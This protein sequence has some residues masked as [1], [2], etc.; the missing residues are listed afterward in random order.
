[1]NHVL[2]PHL[3]NSLVN[4]QHIDD[5]NHVDIFDNVYPIEERKQTIEK[6]FSI[7]DKLV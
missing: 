2:N 1:M 4:V 6:E 3:D 7:I 5:E